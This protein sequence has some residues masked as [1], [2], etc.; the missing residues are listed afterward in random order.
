LSTTISDRFREEVL[1]GGPALHIFVYMTEESPLLQVM[2]SIARF[3]DI[4]AGSDLNNKTFGFVGDR[5]QYREP[6]PVILPVQNAWRWGE[7][8]VALDKEKASSFYDS[9]ANKKQCWLPGDDALRQNIYLPR[10]LYLPTVLGR[11]VVRKKCTPWELHLEV[12]RLISEGITG[13]TQGNSELIREWC[14]AAGQSTAPTRCAPAITLKVN[15]VH[16]DDERFTFWAFHRLG[17]TLGP[18]EQGHVTVGDGWVG[19]KIRINR[20]VKGQAK[21]L[22]FDKK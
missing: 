19:K 3:F 15:A 22:C 5:T 11:F 9:T 16:S 14:L 2:H 10:M 20:R 13:V 18:R 7:V 6:Y 21:A 4:E 1:A 12:E 17:A 8:T